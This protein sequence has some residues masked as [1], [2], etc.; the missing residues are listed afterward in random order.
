[1]IL[2]LWHGWTAPDQ[3]DGYEQLLTGQIAPAIFDRG[4]A[5]LR[6]LR[7]LR[8]DPRELDPATETE[9]LTVMTFDDLAAVASFTGGD[10]SSSVVPAAARRLLS[11]FDD[12]SQH[13]TSRAVYTAHSL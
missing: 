3:T 9:F 4:I 13:Y 5:G 8:R 6:E 10:P 1:M 7:V 11:R 2:R 12:H